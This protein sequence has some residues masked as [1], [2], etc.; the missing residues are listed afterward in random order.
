VER[1]V[2]LLFVLL[3]ACQSGPRRSDPVAGPVWLTDA[4][5]RQRHIVIAPVEDQVLAAPIVTGGRVVFDDSRVAHV[6]SPVAGRISRIDASLGQHV[7]AGDALATLDSPDLG[8]ASAD[9]DKAEADLAA[10]QHDYD[11]QRAL[12]DKQAASRAAFEQAR[13]HYLRARAERDRV[14]QKLLLLT[15]GRDGRITQTYTLRSPI[16]GDV[17]ARRVS[18]GLEVQGL[19]SGGTPAE[20]FTVGRTDRV[21]VLADVREADFARVKVGAPIRVSVVAYP[22]ESFPG[23]VD[24]IAS[25]LDPETRTARVR[26]T[27]ANDAGLL[28][29]EMFATVSISSP[30]RRALALPRDAVVRFGEHTMVFVEAARAPGGATRFDLR[31]VAIDDLETGPWVVVERGLEPGER[32]VVSGASELADDRYAPS[33]PS[34]PSR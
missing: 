7:A 8:I 14:R 16:D 2:P 3:V 13:D 31:P 22:G 4:V 1:V 25:V 19:Y 17:V 28:E 29:P 30:G 23:R 33:S 20:L 10:A 21:W 5:V 15:G 32:V 12:F 18:P 27:L 34:S 11:R 24:W 26:C 6:Y 9:V